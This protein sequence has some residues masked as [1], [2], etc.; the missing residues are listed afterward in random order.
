MQYI[1]YADI[2]YLIRKIG[3]CENNP[4]NSSAIKI[5]EHIPCGYSMLRNLEFDH[6]E[7]KHTLC[8]GKDCL[9]KVS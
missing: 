3:S 9:K 6:L 7:K 2:K 1:I 5:R 4:E 8:C